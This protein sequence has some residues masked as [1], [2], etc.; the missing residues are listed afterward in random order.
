MKLLTPTPTILTLCGVSHKAGTK[1]VL[2]ENRTV[3]KIFLEFYFIFLFVKETNL[4][5]QSPVQLCLLMVKDPGLRLL[6][7]N[8]NHY[9][10]MFNW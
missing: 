10:Y 7:K 2:Q 3:P 6:L 5:L 4:V 8:T 9:V 1:P